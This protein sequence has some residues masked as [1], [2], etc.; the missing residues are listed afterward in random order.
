MKNKTVALSALLVVVAPLCGLSQNG[1]PPSQ[2][3]A[4]CPGQEK[5]ALLAK[6]K[7]LATVPPCGDFPSPLELIYF[8]HATGGRPLG[9]G[10][11][12]GRDLVVTAHEDGEGERHWIRVWAV[13][14]ESLKYKYVLGKELRMTPPFTSLADTFQ[15]DVDGRSET[16]IYIQSASDNAAHDHADYIFHVS[17]DLSAREVPLIHAAHA[18]EPQL[19]KG[20]SIQLAE[21]NSF[22]SLKF[23]CQ[24]WAEGETG[25]WPTGGEVT[26]TYKIIR[27]KTGP[28]PPGRGIDNARR[29][30]P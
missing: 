25:H 12:V 11:G 5:G 27:L 14:R 22:P 10:E 19:N 2:R 21:Y 28:R 3:K 20:E 8:H 6:N 13:D 15:H 1:E 29:S 23:S 16:F 4:L 7:I 18:Y 9:S 30:T 26:G 17:W 24:V